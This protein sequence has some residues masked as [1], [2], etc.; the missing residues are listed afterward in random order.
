MS[1]ACRLTD[2]KRTLIFLNIMISCIASSMLATALTTALPP[3]IQDLHVS[4][5]T[6]QWLTS[7]YSLAMGITMPLTAFLITRFPTRRLYLAGLG[8]FMIGLLTCAVAPNFSV[9]MTARILQACGSGILTSMSQVVL[10]IIYPLEKRGTIMGWYG[11]SIGAAPVIA[12]TLAGV[13]VDLFGWKYIFYIVAAIIAVSFLCALFV[14][15]DVLDVTKKKFDVLSFVI[16]AAAFAGITL[17]IGNIGTYPILDWKVLP[18]LAVGLLAGYWFVR[19]QLKSE[20]PFLELRVLK[21]KEYALSVI[22]S[23]LLYLV[24]MGSA[25]IMPL[26]QFCVILPPSQ[27]W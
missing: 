25:V 3:I 11:L 21:S 9:M 2:R 12:P 7:G 5:S 18:L 19:R 15:D 24:M 16:S 8:I 20:Q 14:F 23:M 17:G 22:G 13:I 6:G 4:V 26:Y 10:L 1:N 27:D